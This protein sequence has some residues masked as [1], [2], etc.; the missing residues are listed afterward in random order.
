M[1]LPHQGQEPGCRAGLC[2]LGLL[3][4]FWKVSEKPWPCHGACF[5]PGSCLESI[6]DSNR[7]LRSWCVTDKSL[8]WSEK[9]DQLAA[10][11]QERGGDVPQRLC[12]EVRLEAGRRLGGF[13][14]RRGEG[15][16]KGVAGGQEMGMK[17][18]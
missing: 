15:L 6:R 8:W 7:D 1:R 13:W 10:V 11:S 17:G 16:S 4:S 9:H 3:R 14:R 12:W 2:P 5:Y 18:I